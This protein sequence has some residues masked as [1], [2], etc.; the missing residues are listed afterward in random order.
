M[1]L[2]K[3]ST[4]CDLPLRFETYSA[5]REAVLALLGRGRRELVMFDRDFSDADLGSCA[6]YDLLWAFFTQQPSGQMRLLVLDADYLGRR[7]ARFTQLRERFS[8]RLEVR[9]LDDPE[10]WHQGFMIADGEFSLVRP[11]FDWPRG[12]LAC[13]S[14]VA[15]KMQQ[16]FGFVW[17]KG[18]TPEEWHALNL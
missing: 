1:D 15:V 8:H 4:P 14:A 2:E 6:A 16:W 13:D 3:M 10:G 11:H 7:C 12:E 9:C 5:Y 17:H 18:N